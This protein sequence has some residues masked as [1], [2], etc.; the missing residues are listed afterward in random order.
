MTSRTLEAVYEHGVLRPLTPL[1]L[2]EGETVHV[3]VESEARS[4]QGADSLAAL[5]R[6]YE[7]WSKEEIAE[8]EGHLKRPMS[9]FER[10]S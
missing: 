8:F 5:M 4:K 3:T 7:G 9:M 1:T 6:V 2:R 10:E